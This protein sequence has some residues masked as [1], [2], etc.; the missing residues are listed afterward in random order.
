MEKVIEKVNTE[1]KTQI[2]NRDQPFR[3]DD[4]KSDT[5]DVRF[6]KSIENIEE[7]MENFYKNIKNKENELNN[8]LNILDNNILKIKNVM[9]KKENII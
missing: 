8:R 7:S 3:P 6:K 4:E 5:P 1:T 2:N 9:N